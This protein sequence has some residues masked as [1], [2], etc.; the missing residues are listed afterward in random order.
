M[1]EKKHQ[2]STTLSWIYLS[3]FVKN[4]SLL[5]IISCAFCG[6]IYPKPKKTSARKGGDREN[7][8]KEEKKEETYPR[9]TS[10][11]GT[12]HG[13]RGVAPHVSVAEDPWF[14]SLLSL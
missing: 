2:H 4:Y 8:A 11:L 3:Q 13:F 7:T 14:P 12:A 6:E 10:S 9:E 5:A 1:Y